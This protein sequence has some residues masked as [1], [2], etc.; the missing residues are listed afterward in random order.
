MQCRFLSAADELRR[1]DDMP[2]HHTHDHDTSMERIMMAQRFATDGDAFWDDARDSHEQAASSSRA[3]GA[4]VWS[5]ARRPDSPVIHEDLLFEPCSRSKRAHSHTSL[6]G[7][8][9]CGICLK[10]F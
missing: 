7:C 2:T 10:Q 6:R 4:N 5:A 3:W 9:T 1:Q 8:G